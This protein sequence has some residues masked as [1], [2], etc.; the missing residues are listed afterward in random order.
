MFDLLNGM[1]VRR[2]KAS[3][4]IIVSFP[5]KARRGKPVL[6][7]RRSWLTQKKNWR[8]ARLPQPFCPCN[9][10]FASSHGQNSCRQIANS[11]QGFRHRERSIPPRSIPPGKMR[12]KTYCSGKISMFIFGKVSGP[13]Q[14]PRMCSLSTA[15]CIRRPLFLKPF[16]TRGD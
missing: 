9:E 3:H 6:A 4:E 2:C 8:T 15:V 12:P 14:V 7:R 1:T 16:N 11:N 5:E 13:R 10:S